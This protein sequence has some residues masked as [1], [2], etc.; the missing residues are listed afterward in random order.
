MCPFNIYN[1]LHFNKYHSVLLEFSRLKKKNYLMLA[2]LPT[3]CFVSKI[4]WVTSTG[5]I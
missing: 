1:Y 2:R 4:K 5:F 3:I